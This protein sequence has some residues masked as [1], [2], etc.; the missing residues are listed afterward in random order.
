VQTCLKK[1]GQYR[2]DFASGQVHHTR[3]SKEAHQNS[4]AKSR[5]SLIERQQGCGTRLLRRSSG[6]YD[7]I[8]S[9]GDRPVKLRRFFYFGGHVFLTRTKRQGWK[10]T[11]RTLQWCTDTSF[12]T[13]HLVETKTE[14]TSRSERPAFPLKQYWRIHDHTRNPESF[15]AE[16]SKSRHFASL[17]YTLLQTYLCIATLQGKRLQ[18][19]TG[20]KAVRP[21]KNPD[22]R[23]VRRRVQSRFKEVAGKAIRV[24]Y[25]IPG[26]AFN[27]FGG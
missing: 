8:E 15:Q 20:S 13:V 22:H 23:S 3:G 2:M 21:C 7:R 12:Q 25:R 11:P 4:K 16:C 26:M 10:K 5:T 1:Y 24:N 14:R 18:L 27:S 19:T 9:D 17:L 6:S